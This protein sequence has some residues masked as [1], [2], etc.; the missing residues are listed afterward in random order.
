MKLFVSRQRQVAGDMSRDFRKSLPRHIVEFTRRSE[1]LVVSFDFAFTEKR[2]TAPRRPWG[3]KFF[4][5]QNASTLGVM[6]KQ[7]DWY[8]DRQ[9]HDFLLSLKR[10]GFFAQFAQCLFVGGSMGGSAAAAF[11]G[12]APGSTVVSINPQS[13]L[14]PSLVPWEKRFAV[15]KACD[16]SGAFVDAAHECRAAAQVYIVY[17]PYHEPDR[18]HAHRFASANVTH[19]HCP[20]YD[21]HLPTHLSRIGA[22]KPFM[23]AACQGTLSA[24][25]FNRLMKRRSQDPVFFKKLYERCRKKRRWARARKLAEIA[26]ARLAAQSAEMIYFRSRLALYEARQGKLAKAHRLLPA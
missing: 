18:L 19:L 6:V 25:D 15:G 26:C 1:S 24:A 9:L 11:S 23:A 12:I 8:R 3:H 20:F 16:W 7:T 2:A 17:D 5:E 22:L 14:S 21:H 10:N 13:T 4:S